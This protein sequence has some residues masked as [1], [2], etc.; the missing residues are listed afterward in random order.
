MISWRDLKW[1][2]N[3][4]GGANVRILL[5]GQSWEGRGQVIE[6]EKAV[7]KSLFDYYQKAPKYAKY[8]GIDLDAAKLPVST[9]CAR[10]AQRLVMVR[11]DL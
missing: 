2:K 1:W 9:D 6:E 4:R 3:L 7:A 5:A 11:V 10:A 8:V